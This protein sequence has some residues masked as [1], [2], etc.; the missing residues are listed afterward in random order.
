M[1]IALQ[2]DKIQ[3]VVE[4]ADAAVQ[5]GTHPS[6]VMAVADSQ[7][8]RWSY[9]TR[10]TDHPS[11]NLH[12]IF[13]LASITKPIISSLV[14]RLIEQGRL[15]LYEPIARHIPEF[16]RRGK[17]RV[18]AWHLLTHTSGLNEAGMGPLFE[19]RLPR[20]AW[21]AAA[22]DAHLNFPLGERYEYCTLSFS[23]LAELVTRL[24]GMPDI[25]SLRSQLCDPLGMP[26]TAYKPVDPERAAPVFT[27][28]D[29]SDEFLPY[30][31]SVAVPGGGLWSTA[32]DLVSFGQTFLHNGTH[33]GYRL[34]SPPAVELM[35]RSHTDGLIE[36]IEGFPFPAAYG[37]GWGKPTLRFAALA[38][39]RAVQHGGATGTLLVV[40]PTYDLVF[41]FLTNRWSIPC[42]VAERALHAVYSALE[43][44][45]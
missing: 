29:M 31:T 38:S 20:E 17:E 14:L 41:V 39:P 27:T 2:P 32:A 7:E 33:N 9:T 28:P 26:D 5:E 42:E 19:E 22:C 40:D 44:T 18:T 12:T 21:L 3:R 16:A 30:F 10:R 11:V 15:L 23:V 13:L 4:I 36:L 45:P 37:L 25:V 43:I 6:I 24:S 1:P 8:V 34:L 35:T